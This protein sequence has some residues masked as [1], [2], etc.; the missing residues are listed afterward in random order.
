MRSRDEMPKRDRVAAAPPAASSPGDETGNLFDD[1]V[2]PRTP[3]DAKTSPSPAS[4]ITPSK[5]SPARSDRSAPPIQP[6][7]VT[8]GSYP[9]LTTRMSPEP[10]KP[11]NGPT[12]ARNRGIDPSPGPRPGTGVGPSTSGASA[13]ASGVA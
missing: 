11:M 5:P 10:T 7:D 8:E 3:S 12:S 13:K 1:A 6:S 9:P 4:P 2:S